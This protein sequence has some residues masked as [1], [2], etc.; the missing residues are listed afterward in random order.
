MPWC[1]PTYSWIRSIKKIWVDY[2]MT[3]KALFT[4]CDAQK[5]NW[6]CLC[7]NKWL[8]WII[9]VIVTVLYA[10]LLG[11]VTVTLVITVP[12][13]WGTCFFF[14]VLLAIGRSPTPNCFAGTPPAPPGPPAAPPPLPA[15]AITEPADKTVFPDGDTTPISWTATVTNAD[16]SAVISP[17]V[18]W[19]YHRGEAP[20]PGPTVVLGDGAHLAKTLPHNAVDKAAGRLTRYHVN[21]VFSTADGRAVSAEVTIDVG[22]FDGN[23]G[24]V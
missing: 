8:C 24:P 4:A 17:A 2:W 13:C 6:W 22:N 5:C 15:I 16:G 11:L 14:F 9:A 23:G 12:T 18:H 19:S 7:C 20:V 3:I 10:A 21:A 1:A